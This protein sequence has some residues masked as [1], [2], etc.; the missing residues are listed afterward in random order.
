MELPAWPHLVASLRGRLLRT[1]A[2]Y[3]LDFA[4]DQPEAEAL[5]ERAAS[6]DPGGDSQVLDAHLAL[7]RRDMKAALA[8]LEIP[9]SLQARHLKA[10]ILI[11]DGDGESALGI[12][13]APA[14][15]AEDSASDA[16]PPSDPTDAAGNT[17]ETW[18]LR[19]LAS[20]LLK[21]LP[22]AVE[23]IDAARALAPD[24]IA[25]RS[26]A[27]MI[28]FWRVCTPAALTLTEQPLWPMPF[29]R[30][31]VRA[32]AGGR[33]AE[34]EQT[35][36]TV[37]GAMPTGSAEQG[38]WLTWRLVALLAAGN[39]RDA[40]TELAKRLI[41]SDGPLHI[42]PL[43]WARF[44]D[45][46]I[47]RGRLKDRLKS[48]PADDPNFI[49]LTG[50][51]LELRL[52]DGE[53]E[54]VLAELVEIAP[55]VEALG[56]PEVPRQWRVLA[57]TEAGR[58]ND[59]GAVVDTI[60]DERLRLRMRLHVARSQET[61]TPGSHKAAAAALLAADPGLDVLAEAC[62]AHAKAGDWAFVAAHADALLEAIPTPGSLRLLAIATFNLGE[63]QRCLSALD[64]HRY[65]Y[66]DDRLPD[67]LALLRVRCQRMLGD[68]SHAACDARLLFEQAPT[69]EH[70]AELLNAQLEGADRGGMLD[71]LRRMQVIDVTDGELLLQATRIAIQLDRE[72][73]ISL[74]RRAVSLSSEAPEFPAQ[75]ATLGS[76]LGLRDEETGP[77]FQRMAELAAAG[78]GGGRMF[79]I[80]EALGILRDQRET[81][82]RL[83]GLYQQGDLPI[84]GLIDATLLPLTAHHHELPSRNRSDPDPLLQAAIPIRHG[85][86]PMRSLKSYRDQGCRL[87]LDMTGLITAQSLGLLDLVER[88]FAPLLIPRQWHLLLRSEIDRLRSS[89][90]R[91]S[92]AVEQV[93]RL[94]RSGGIELADLMAG[95]TPP[96]TLSSL[97]GERQAREL[98]LVEAMGGRL[99]TYLP[100]HGPDLA[101][102]QAVELPSE[103]DARCPRAVRHVGPFA[104][105]GCDWA[106]RV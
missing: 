23:A 59:A 52:E 88:T 101:Q 100:L 45:L 76:N 39:S 47:D 72:L 80:S 50:L 64:E 87:V 81:N 25:V 38:H 61:E 91:R 20:L 86:R 102:Y 36:A 33:L 65:V 78:E 82:D 24:W 58:L 54:V 10:A 105:G 21:R 85:A 106:K 51:Y 8:I 55:T 60:A 12:L 92:A 43:I 57:L 16:A 68:V 71:S 18:R 79:H 74:W 96:E 93:A 49:P 56:H 75:A 17:A 63:Y 53:A 67:N 6:E 40:A 3:R 14:E 41:G 13:A 34:I 7:H 99:L 32:D 15:P 42:W 37:A 4:Q 29:L 90:P 28:D 9:R 97:V 44:F 46:D 66:G 77:W 26:A 83:W 22:D 94:I 104:C 11:E 84:H 30:A 73:A 27:A 70:L 89:Q 69:A 35:F 95:P 19:A 2:L 103:C 31:L 5:T 98:A 62:D 1:A 48:I